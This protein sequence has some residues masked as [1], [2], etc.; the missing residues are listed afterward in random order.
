MA[1]PRLLIIPAVLLALIALRA[2]VFMWPKPVVKRR[3]P[4][5][6]G[7]GYA[8][9][10]ADNP[11]DER[12][13]GVLYAKLITDPE[14]GL[15]GKPDMIFSNGT[16][17]I[18]VELKSGKIGEDTKPHTGDLMQLVSYFF[19][20]EAEFGIR[21]REG[22]LIYR[23]AMFIV[24]NTRGL[25]N[26]LLDILDEMRYVAGMDDGEMQE[27]PKPASPHYTKCLHCPCRE[28]VCEFNAG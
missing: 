17:L 3:K 18:P 21:P 14:T 7:Y 13:P 1:D 22:R 11:K 20:A 4:T 25:R 27:P 28:T 15:R 19:L 9:I 24:R 6:P 10:Y 12:K 26:K 2:V 8:L 23:D 16:H 5:L